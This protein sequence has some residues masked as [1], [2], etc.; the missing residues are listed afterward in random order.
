MPRSLL[1]LNS[2][3]VAV[4]PL[5][6]RFLA[7]SNGMAKDIALQR[8]EN[9]EHRAKLRSVRF[10]PEPSN[11]SA[12]SRPRKQAVWGIRTKRCDRYFHDERLDVA[13]ASRSIPAKFSTRVRSHPLATASAGN[14]RLFRPGLKYSPIYPK[15]SRIR[16]IQRVAKRF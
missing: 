1:D 14:I 16:M 12:G 9:S 11:W 5:V 13:M 6:R 7:K 15:S 3:P 2:P 4:M 10:S 8:A